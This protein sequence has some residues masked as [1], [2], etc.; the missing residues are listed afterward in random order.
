MFKF[1]I[2]EIVINTPLSKG[3]NRSE[4]DISDYEEEISN[5]IRDLNTYDIQCRNRSEEDISDYEEEVNG[6]IRKIRNNDTR[7]EVDMEYE[8]AFVPENLPKL[9]SEIS[10]DDETQNV[11]MDMECLAL[12]I[13]LQ[14]KNRISM[15]TEIEK[16]SFDKLVETLSN[17]PLNIVEEIYLENYYKGL[18][19]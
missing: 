14:P 2:P 7:M 13:I 10:T 18:T 9:L 5:I 17:L 1:D 4:E 19:K 15:L 3:R 8:G 16:E 6:I 11:E 12:D